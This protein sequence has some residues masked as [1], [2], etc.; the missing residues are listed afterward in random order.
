MMLPYFSC[1][2]HFFRG[3]A[4]FLS[5]CHFFLLKARLSALNLDMYLHKVGLAYTILFMAL[6]SK[7]C[8][9]S[10]K[11][12]QNR[13]INIV[14]YALNSSNS[15]IYHNLYFNHIL[16]NLPESKEKHIKQEIKLL[17]NHRPGSFDTILV[18]F[19]TSR[20]DAIRGT[21]SQKNEKS[22]TQALARSSVYNR[23]LWRHNPNQVSTSYIA[24]RIDFSVQSQQQ[25]A[26]QRHLVIIRWVST[27]P[28]SRIF[29]TWMSNMTTERWKTIFENVEKI[30]I[31]N[32]FP[33]I[34]EVW[35][36]QSINEF[37][38]KILI[39]FQLFI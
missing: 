10:V 11:N 17:L 14:M 24:S 3:I 16:K 32:N 27:F 15:Y 23:E 25:R 18:P 37:W 36:Q 8:K 34:L 22:F 28:F 5:A 7:T 38:K 12:W 30:K 9:E 2:M 31:F 39:L 33:L 20:M 29:V 19:S 4:K 6:W 21:Q 35:V 13:N 1:K 26:L